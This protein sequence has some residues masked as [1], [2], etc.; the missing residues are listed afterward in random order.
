MKFHNVGIYVKVLS[1]IGVLRHTCNYLCVY[2]RHFC[3]V[4]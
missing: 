4:S 1:L 2:Y 3:L